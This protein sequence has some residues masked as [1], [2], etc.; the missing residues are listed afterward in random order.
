VSKLCLCS[1]YQSS[2]GHYIINASALDP[3]RQISDGTD[4][5]TQARSA[6]YYYKLYSLLLMHV[7]LEDGVKF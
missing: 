7:M 3:S 2:S 6:P 5:A 4:I 1:Q